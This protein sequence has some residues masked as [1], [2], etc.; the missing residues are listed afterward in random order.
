MK[1]KV[2]AA[3]SLVSSMEGFPMAGLDL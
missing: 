1:K 2:D 3:A